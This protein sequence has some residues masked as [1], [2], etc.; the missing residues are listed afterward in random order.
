MRATNNS[1]CLL[2]LL[3]L[4]VMSSP[5]S[6][7]VAASV[8]T[9]N[10]TA[11]LLSE[12]AVAQPGQRIAVLLH[13]TIRPGWHTYWRNPGDSGQPTQ[14]KW[15]LPEG[16]T[17]SP[18]EWP[19]PEAIRVG[20]LVNYGYSNQVGLLS[21][22][23]LPSSWQAGQPLQITAEAN[24]LVCEH[25]CIPESGTFT[26]SLPTAMTSVPAVTHAALFSAARESQP[27]ALKWPAR[28]SV[29]DGALNLHLA[30]PRA[31]AQQVR[32]AQFFPA[33]WGAIDHAAAQTVQVLDDGLL[34]S[35]RKGELPGPGQ[36]RGIVTLTL[37]DGE[38]ASR[39]SYLLDDTA[40]AATNAG[41]SPDAVPVSVAL[42]LLSALLG[43]A[44]LNLMPCVF[45]ILAMK[46]LSFVGHAAASPRERVSGGLAYAAGVLL[47][48]TALGGVLLALK[49]AG[50]TIGWGFQLQ[51]PI[52]VA[53]L[54]Y[55]LFAAGL[56]LS[57]VFDIGGRFMGVGTGLADRAGFAGS[58]F[59]GVLAAV[60][61]TPCTAPFMATAVGVALTQPTWVAL[62]TFLMLGLGL[63]LPY[64][65]L[66]WFPAVARALP[67][68]GAWMNTFKH[69]LA[70]LLY[71]SAAW[72]VW[73][74][75]QQSG[76][77]GVFV[78]LLGCI[79]IAFSVWLA[80]LKT[81]RPWTHRMR[82]AALLVVIVAG[83][84]FTATL[85]LTQVEVSATQTAY[86]IQPF[87]ESALNE[88]RAQGKPVFLNMTAAWC[89]TCKVNERIALSGAAFQEALRSG[90][91]AYLKGDW[92]RQNPE[93]TRLLATFGRAGVPLY[94]VYPAQGEP[95]VLPQ[96]LTESI[97]VEALARPA[98]SAS[99]T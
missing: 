9:Q 10:V 13:Q 41:A 99:S 34:I 14:I 49:A 96:V 72:L 84:W 61:A 16:V 98:L 4:A 46:A 64:L 45:P 58:F 71:I 89:I 26:L 66:T 21:Y 87:S 57:G 77:D 36:P 94:V 30:L 95:Y 80:Q 7:D 51:N 27:Q 63:A 62:S 76:A 17:V 28:L 23:T 86:S 82:H 24:W 52:T 83:V 92:T 59:T 53:V 39:Q 85:R 81:L 6:A 8:Q 75:A 90:G 11:Q 68:P 60:V 25:E 65:L 74:L 19:T 50:N 37:G 47:S 29:A 22:L 93:I 18:I 67:R 38:E 20:P 73:V 48:F 33:E 88:L 91:Y 32:T 79:A 3:L 69:L 5:V 31:T 2:S 56:N 43:G 97:V 40:P 35:T 15:Q 70:F 54:A 42:I 12:A 44:L 1:Y 55:V 78:V